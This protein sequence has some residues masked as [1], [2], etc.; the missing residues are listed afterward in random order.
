VMNRRN[1]ISKERMQQAKKE[2]MEDP[3]IKC[4]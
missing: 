3:K 2:I 1:Q 4:P